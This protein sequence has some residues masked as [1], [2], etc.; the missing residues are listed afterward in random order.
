MFKKHSLAIVVGAMFVAPAAFADDTASVGVIYQVDQTT[1]LANINQSQL[2]GSP[3]AAA[4]LQIDS[5]HGGTTDNNNIGTVIQGLVTGAGGVAVDETGG[6]FSNTTT[7]L[8][9]GGTAGVAAWVAPT[10]QVLA[11]YETDNAVVPYQFNI[12]NPDQSNYGLVL[13]NGQIESQ[14][15]IIQAS[16]AESDAAIAAQFSLN[17]NGTDLPANADSETRAGTIGDTLALTVLDYSGQAA[18]ETEVVVTYGDGT[19]T[20]NYGLD[21]LDRSEERRV[22]KE[23]RRLCRSRWSPYH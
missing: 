1:S 17:S 7:D 5:A 16:G 22:G 12:V 4:I 23:C 9:D 11:D 8:I 21:D 14:A 10:I 18:G 15:I 2:D 6:I 3:Q 20:V 13:Q 19:F